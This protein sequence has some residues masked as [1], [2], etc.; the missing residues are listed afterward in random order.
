MLQRSHRA[1]FHPVVT[2]R[3]NAAQRFFAVARQPAR[4]AGRG[5][6]RGV[7]ARLPRSVRVCRAAAPA[8]HARGTG[9]RS[10]AT[11]AWSPIWRRRGA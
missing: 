3:A 1:S 10:S 2:Y 7:A 4:D 6:G 8:P 5:I 9:R 11:R